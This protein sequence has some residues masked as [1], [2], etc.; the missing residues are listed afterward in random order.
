MKWNPGKSS[1]KT[2]TLI[3]LLVVIAI[4]AILAA[5][6]GD[7]GVWRRLHELHRC[8]RC[9]SVFSSRQPRMDTNQ[10]EWENRL[11]LGFSACKLWIQFLVC[12]H[13]SWLKTRFHICDF[14]FQS[15]TG[16]THN[17][18]RVNRRRGRSEERRVGKECRSR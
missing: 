11:G 4:I 13:D 17:G 7:G 1:G 14:R 18:Q 10:H 5:L 16:A 9:F 15:A 12:V 8:M 2:F 3:E 6:S